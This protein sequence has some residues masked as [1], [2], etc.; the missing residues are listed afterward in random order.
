VK[1]DGVG[2][3]DKVFQRILDVITALDK[4]DS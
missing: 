2:E 3:E 1:V 4:L